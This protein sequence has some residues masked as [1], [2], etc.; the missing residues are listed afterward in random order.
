VLAD[1]MQRQQQATV[2]ISTQIEGLTDAISALSNE[3]ESARQT[4]AHSGEAARTGASV[5]NATLDEIG[6]IASTIRDSAANVEQLG[7]QSER[8][9]EVVGLIKD[10]AGQTNLLALNAAIE[11]ARAGEQG[12]GFA[13]VADEVRKLA[14][15]TAAATEEISGMID[16]IRSSR[17]AALG[18]IE[19]AVARVGNGTRLA[20]EAEGSIA[21]I[22]DNAGKVER[23]VEDIARALLDQQKGAGAIALSVETIAGM[24]QDSA[25]SAGKVA[26]EVG[27]LERSAAALTDAVQ[28]FRLS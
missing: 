9:A 11:A 26:V 15:R 1:L 27:G 23:V 18:S 10:I 17:N 6:G 28:R 5:V 25:D 4:A 7:K 16:D 2:G 3:A 8:V 21:Q 24:A 22:T 12:R 14:E 13:V 20:A 19:N